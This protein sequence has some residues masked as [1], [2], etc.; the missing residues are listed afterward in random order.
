MHSEINKI[1][2]DVYSWEKYINRLENHFEY[3]LKNNNSNF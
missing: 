1:N 3:I 2:N